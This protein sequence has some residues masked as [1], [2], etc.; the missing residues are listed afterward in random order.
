MQHPLRSLA[1][2]LTLTLAL[3]AEPAAAAAPRM[4]VH[5]PCVVKYNRRFRNKL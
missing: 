1:L 2:I 5:K 4:A 3:G